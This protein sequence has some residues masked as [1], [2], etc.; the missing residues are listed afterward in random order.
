MLNSVRDDVNGSKQYAYTAILEIL[1]AFTNIILG[2][3]FVGMFMIFTAGVTFY[4][5]LTKKEVR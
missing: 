2:Q 4:N 5:V 3:W 1:V